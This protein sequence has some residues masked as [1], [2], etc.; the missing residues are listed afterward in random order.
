MQCGVVGLGVMGGNLALNLEEHGFPVAV[1]DRTP[2]R[3]DAFLAENGARRLAGARTFQELAAAIERPRR[4]LLLVPAGDPVEEVLA[5]LRP[6]LEKGDLVIDGANSW[7]E[8]TR[9]REETLRSVGLLFLG[10]GVSGGEE[11]AR[12]G[13][14]LMPGGARESYDLARPLLEAIAARTPDGSCVAHVGPDG[15]GHFVKM[16]HNGIEYGVLQLLAEVYDLFTRGLG[17]DAPASSAVFAEWNG[18][19]LES[20]LVE[21]ASRVLAAR[22]PETGK[23][24]VDLVED[25]AEQKGTG[26]WTLQAALDLGVPV[27]TISAG[28][29]ARLLSSRKDWR[30]YAAQRL[31][32]PRARVFPGSRDGWM[33][34][35]RETYHASAIVAYAQ[36]MDL[37]GAAS[38]ANRW[39]VDRSEVARIWKGGCIVRARLLDPIR[40]A[41]RRDKALANLLLARP[42]VSV[43]RKAQGRWR[44]T[45]GTAQR[46]GLPVPAL[47]ASL[48]YYD[49][50]RTER[51]PQ[52]LTQAQRDAFGSHR[53]T[54]VDHPERGPVHTDW[55]AESSRQG[56]R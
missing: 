45:I 6:F 34:A 47:A 40:D 33:A 50:A 48:A 4:I 52:N 5:G 39:G 9:R 22:D 15:S 1:W 8:D 16:A 29:E 20:F 42:F 30:A 44:R 53:Y 21:L 23:P 32:G 2:A 3:T 10:C 25:R 41:Y 46:L 36:G 28:V 11:G 54:R 27:P 38:E 51:L 49:A 12:R 31:P 43:L 17:L 13:P 37:I 24:L 56:A 14:C 19:P 18:G 7:F 35:F 55:V 26:K